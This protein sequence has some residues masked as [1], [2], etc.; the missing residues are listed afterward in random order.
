V[1]AYAD[2]TVAR[3]GADFRHVRDKGC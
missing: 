1:P 2:G 3:F